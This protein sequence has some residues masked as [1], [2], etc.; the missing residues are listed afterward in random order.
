MICPLAFTTRT[1]SAIASKT[2]STT[3]TKT[4]TW[5]RPIRGRNHQRS[6]LRNA[7]EPRLRRACA[8]A[9]RCPRRESDRVGSVARCSTCHR[10]L[11]SGQACPEHGGAPAPLH[12]DTS[13]TPNW[14]QPL[15]A[16][17]GSGGFA[18]VWEIP[19]GEVLKVAHADHDLGRA[20]IAREAEALAAIGA[21]AVPRFDSQGVLE[22]GRAWIAMERIQ[23]TTLTE[24]TTEGPVPAERVL[25][26]AIA[27]LTALD[28][29]HAAG[30]VHRDLKPD[31]LVLCED[32][33]IVILDLGLA[34]KIP[35]DPDDPTR[36]KVKVGSLEYIPVEQLIDPASVD[37]R[38]DLYA[39]GCV[40]YELCAGRP[41]FLGDAAAL[42]R[43]HAVLRPPP[44]GAMAKVPTS[45]EAMINELLAKS[46]ARRPQSAGEVRSRLLSMREVTPV[47]QRASRSVLR[48]GKQPVVLLWAELPKVDRALLG[49]LTARKIIVVSQRGRKVLGGAVGAEH[50]DPA[51]AAISAARDLAAAGARVALHLHALRVN[52]RSGSIVIDGTGLQQPEQ[53]LPPGQ[54]TGIVLTRALASVVNA[55]TLPTDLGPEF[56]ALGEPGRS[57]SGRQLFG[58]EAL[59]GDLL[60]DA[61]AAFAGSGPALSL[62]IGDPGI[63][64]T[65]IAAALVPRL[66]ELGANVYAAA[67]SPPG[68]ARGRTSGA[69]EMMIGV[70][71]EPTV[72]SVGDALRTVA[73]TKPTAVVVDDIHLAEHDLLD[74][75]EYATLGGETLPLWI[76]ALATPRLDQ[77][78][79]GFGARAERK[80]RDVLPPLDQD[81]ATKM[82]AA[83]LHPAEYPPLRALRQIASIAHGNPMHLRALTRELHDRGAVKV[84]PNGEHFLDTTTLDSLPSVAIGPWLA[85]RELSALSED[86]AS[87]ARVCAVLGDEIDR[88]ELVAVIEA[89]ERAGGATTS[90]DVDAGLQE[91]TAAGILIA[92]VDG[93]AFRTTLLQEGI[94]TTTEVA[95]RGVLHHAALDMWRRAGADDLRAIE[96]IARHAEAVGERAT[97]ATAFAT[98]G[99]RAH[100]Q[101]RELDADQAWQGAVRNLDARDEHR[102]QALLG[103]ARVRYRLQRVRDALIDLDEVLDI[104]ATIA[105]RRLELEA[106]LERATALD[107]ADDFEGSKVAAARAKQLWSANAYPELA[108]E[109]QLADARS[110]WRHRDFVAA[111]PLFREVKH[112]ASRT[113][114]YEAEIIAT[115]L[116]A[117]LLV[118]IG[119]LDAARAEFEELIPRCQARDDRFYLGAAYTNRSWLWSA[120]GDVDRCADDL[121][122]VIQIAREIGQAVLERTATYNL[123]ESMLW[124]GGLEE[125]LRLARR[126][127]TL[128][129]AY[130]E[131]AAQFDLLLEAR[132]QAARGDRDALSLLIS[133]LE[134]SALS[135]SDNAVLTVLRCVVDGAARS[136]WQAAL[137]PTAALGVD[138]QLELAYLAKQADRLPGDLVGPLKQLAT[139]HPIWSRRG[140]F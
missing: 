85:A 134:S 135:S 86:L 92:G 36:A 124:A 122:Q 22:D 128:Q 16:C 5:S 73:R 28:R 31:N 99:Q 96:R 57:N 75:L 3:P 30:F 70:H 112:T 49:M 97:A 6:A 52:T 105:N 140:V 53:W 133:G 79:P 24:L 33:S 9:R 19:D 48:E 27:T 78:R 2:F 61:A 64:K 44:L 14:S 130:G 113:N 110:L 136:A 139:A 25:E 10:R 26:I 127:V 17:I 80:R 7:Y 23:G 12:A 108:A 67:I 126:S 18:S 41:P 68:V 66:R 119:N 13:A 102:G 74:A 63:G 58:R 106:V 35:T 95:E 81:A 129:S 34:R 29:V 101:H 132:V 62:M 88:S 42:E 116:L 118:D 125:A 45:F 59:L 82:T 21:P 121:R 76:F 50:A 91:L 40:L 72:R 20:R 71:A 39:L 111:E 89:V 98:L 38:A 56:V 60:A 51:S 83:L 104:A 115:L 137:A 131:G 114:R 46:P 77:R 37:Q 84:R 87:L 94:Y 107:W 103:R 4:L 43:A 120:S 1:G 100:D 15:G 123:A 117:T 47:F 55:P 54:W 8:G 32:G 90:I 109:V 69:L 138:T 11:V 93:W 65:A